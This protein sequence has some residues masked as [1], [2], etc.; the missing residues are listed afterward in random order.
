VQLPEKYRMVLV[1]RDVE[2]FSTEE[3]A[4]IMNLT[5]SNV[6]VRLHRARL[7]MKEQLKHYFKDEY[8]LP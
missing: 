3:A 4:Q 2:H 7:F 6:K 8:T 1:L 5:P